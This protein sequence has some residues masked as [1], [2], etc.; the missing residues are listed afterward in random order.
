MMISI[1]GPNEASDA[2]YHTAREIGRLLA[3]AGHTVVCGGRGGVME[4]VARGSK[5]AGGTT[6]GILPD[7]DPGIANQ[8][9]DYPIPTGLGHARNT[10][11]VSTGASVIAVGGGFGTLSE[12]GLALKMGKRVV[13]VGSWELD[14][15]R[16]SNYAATTAEYLEATSAEDAVELATSPKPASPTGKG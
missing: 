13:H 8:Y 1:C 12:I 9:I 2:E 4:A 5:D 6:I 7:Y 14:A 10:I 11:V 3:E 15:S 16:V